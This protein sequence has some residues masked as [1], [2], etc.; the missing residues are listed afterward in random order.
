MPKSLSF[1]LKHFRLLLR[2]RGK[3]RYLRHSFSQEGEDVVLEELAGYKNTL[4][5]IYIDVGA[6]HPW[7]F[8]NTAM[9]YLRGWNGINIDA[10]PGTKRLFDK[11]RGMDTNIECAVGSEETLKTYYVYNDSALNGIDR[12]RSAELAQTSFRLLETKPVKTQRLEAILD[13][14]VKTLPSVN[15][16]SV[17]VE[18][19]DLEVLKSN[20][21]NK[22]P[23][24][25]V[26]AEC[27]GKTFEE[28]LQ[29]ETCIYLKCL[30][31]EPRA[32]TGRTTIF[33]RPS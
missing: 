11:E 22:Y 12:D 13:Q 19:Y 29:S 30:G 3:N 16:L 20:N 18:G 23:F 15:F 5:G 21:W 10:N 1:T 31:Y 6:H 2:K 25:W 28:I 14:H 26:M 17:D 7:R 9:F 8:S 24:A 27:G 33:A 32:K 4:S